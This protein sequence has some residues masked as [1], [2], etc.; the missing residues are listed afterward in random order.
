[1]SDDFVEEEFEFYT[2]GPEAGE[3]IVEAAAN[4]ELRQSTDNY[5]YLE[6]QLRRLNVG[7]VIVI[8]R[9]T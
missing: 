1:M 8:T 3:M 7:D 6:S 5:P 4:S 2:F 9:T